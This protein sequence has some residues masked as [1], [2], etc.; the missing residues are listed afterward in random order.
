MGALRAP[1]TLFI[2]MRM[3]TNVT[4]CVCALRP[5]IPCYASALPC[6][7]I[8]A[9]GYLVAKARA[10][11]PMVVYLVLTFP[12]YRAFNLL[13]GGTFARVSRP[14]VSSPK[15][16]VVYRSRI[17]A[18]RQGVAPLASPLTHAAKAALPSVGR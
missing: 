8:A 18:S 1:S 13:G 11:A 5:L 17:C 4:R 2:A 7:G 16:L 15:G 6:F 9:R 3:V 14:S 12:R 10:R